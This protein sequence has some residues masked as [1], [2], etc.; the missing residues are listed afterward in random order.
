MDE[1]FVYVTYAENNSYISVKYITFF[2]H[3]QT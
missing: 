3:A 2:K 1:K